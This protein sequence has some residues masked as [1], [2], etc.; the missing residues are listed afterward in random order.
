[1]DSYLYKSVNFEV[2]SFAPAATISKHLSHAYK[3]LTGILIA[4][5]LVSNCKMWIFLG[6]E[7]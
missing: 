4:N 2:F 5:C 7:M 3:A 1:M 6:V